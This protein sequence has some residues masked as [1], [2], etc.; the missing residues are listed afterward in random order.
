MTPRIVVVELNANAMVD[1]EAVVRVVEY[2]EACEGEEAVTRK[3]R[4]V[5]VGVE[6]VGGG[7]FF[8]EPDKSTLNVR[9]G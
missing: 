2:W 3:R 8:W 1:P 5:E 7:R 4:E 9:P 6:V